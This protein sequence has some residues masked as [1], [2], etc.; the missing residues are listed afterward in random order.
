MRGRKVPFGG[1]LSATWLLTAARAVV[2][3]WLG[4]G[5][6]VF[7][8]HGRA[9]FE[10]LGR[11]DGV[12]IAIVCVELAGAILFLFTRTAI[13]GGVVLAILLAW[14][15]GFHF[16]VGEASRM[17]FVFLSAVLALSGATRTLLARESS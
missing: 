7:L 1:K 14:V 12:R 15:A 5:A 9:V 13:A 8:M 17:L 6:L 3:V 16:A 2:A 10:S 11:P 4:R